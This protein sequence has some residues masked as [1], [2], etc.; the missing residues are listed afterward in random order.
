VVRARDDEHVAGEERLV[1]EEGHR[2]PRLRDD[3]RRQLPLD[4]LAEQALLRG[5]RTSIPTFAYI[6]RHEK[7][8]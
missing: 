6:R 3:V 2:V 1:I 4:D 5:H 7:A 8:E